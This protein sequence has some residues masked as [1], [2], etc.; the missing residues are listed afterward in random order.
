MTAQPNNSKIPDLLSVLPEPLFRMKRFLLYKIFPG[1]KPGKTIKTPFYADGGPRKGLLDTAADLDRLVTLEEAL[2]EF[3]VGGYS[4]IGFALSGDGI[5]AFDFDYCL[6]ENGK[7]LKSHSGYEI[8]RKAKDMG[9]YIEV[10]PSGRGLRIVGPCSVEGAYSKDGTEVWSAKRYVTLT[11]DVWANPK[12]WVGLDPL[13]SPLGAPKERVEHEDDD[14]GPIITPKT[15]GELKSALDAISSDER[16]LWIRMGMALKTIGPKGKALWMAWSAKSEKFVE[17]DAERV[18][19]SFEPGRT[20]YKAVFSEAQGHWDWDNPGK[21]TKKPFSEDPEEDD[22]DEE[23]DEAPSSR[24]IDLGEQKL[25]PTEY[26]L[27]GFLPAQVSVI[28]GAWGAGKSTNLIPLLASAAHLSPEEWGF[29]PTLR[30]HIVWVTEA[31]EQARDTLY[32][33]AKSEG[34]APWAEFKK[35]FHLFPAKRL[36][37][38][39]MARQL[40]RLAEELTTTAEN[41]YKVKPVIVLDTTTANLDL[42]NE[43]DNSV[44]GA[45]MSTLKQALPS[46]PIV[47]IG[48][49][50]KALVKSD[51]AD[52]TFRGAGAWEAEA[53]AT[54]FLVYD[55]D[56]EMRFLAIRKARFT[57]DYREIDFDHAGGSEIVETPWGEPQS[58]GYLHGVPSKSDGQARRAAREE[59]IEER[60]QEQQERSRS[61]RQQRILD[62]VRQCALDGTLATRASIRAEVGGKNELLV[63]AT[64]RLTEAG[65]LVSHHIGTRVEGLGFGG[66]IPD[67]VLP[68][69]VDLEAFLDR[70]R[71]NFEER[72]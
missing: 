40:K 39:A 69:E 36:S 28:A 3:M 22:E 15:L 50:P 47:L 48:H 2:D 61:D 37:P 32:S 11:G 63:E 9:A 34:A 64:N 1:A 43:S 21:K 46:T 65:L 41:G 27:D 45:A 19:D 49:T 53:A 29:N 55:Q 35:W 8:I 51:V 7:L 31:P 13:R 57:P 23:E 20:N 18:W 16:E 58:K 72:E 62:F 42:E 60:R 6:S 33:L 71:A 44:V 17:A 5:A 25:F 14:D 59:V 54:Y 26:I 56:T 4:G 52:M 70:A 12:G 38:K 68:P 10:S 24:Q 67:I 30:R 66:R